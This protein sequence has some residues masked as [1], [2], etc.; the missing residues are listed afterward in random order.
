MMKKT[1]TILFSIVIAL[2]FVANQIGATFLGS[3]FLYYT[4]SKTDISQYVIL[5]SLVGN[6]LILITAFLILKAKKKPFIIQVFSLVPFKKNILPAIVIVSYSIFGNMLINIIYSSEILL[7][8]TSS[9]AEGLKSHYLYYSLAAYLISPIVEEIV[10]RGIIMTKLRTVWSAPSAI[11]ISALIFGLTHAMTGS[12][13][14]V[15]F[16]FG[17]G[18]VFALCYEKTKSLL[19][20][21]LI[22]VIGNLCEL[23][24]EILSSM[25]QTEYYLVIISG[26][27]FLLSYIFLARAKGVRCDRQLQNERK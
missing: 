12:I 26:T 20:I 1:K 5:F 27:I 10:F 7:D 17:G 8:S 6:I 23:P 3:I 4:N 25:S 18:L 21:I 9:M 15:L 14:T 13:L 22:H 16:A 19:L 24:S 2:I 11:F